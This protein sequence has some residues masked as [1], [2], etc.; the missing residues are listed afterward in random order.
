LYPKIFEKKT[1]PVIEMFQKQAKLI[2][3]NASSSIPEIIAEIQ[4]ALK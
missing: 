1:K 3:I 4:K 2:T